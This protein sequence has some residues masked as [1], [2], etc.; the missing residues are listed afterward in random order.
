MP[1]T[2]QQAIFTTEEAERFAK[3]CAGFDV[4][5]AS[6]AEAMGKGRAL[7]RMLVEKKIR[8]VDALEMPEIRKALD[9]QMQPVRSPIP[10]VAALQAENEDLSKKLAF[11]VP[12][13]REI[14]EALAAKRHRDD[15]LWSAFA[16]G[17]GVL[18]FV[19]AVVAVIIREN[20]A[21]RRSRR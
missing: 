2:Q 7:R 14:T 1:V 4:C 17:V 5:N 10:D 18:S 11:V 8:L 20:V 19:S 13:F 16:L 12:K 9:D 15:F 3:L 21:W 6:E